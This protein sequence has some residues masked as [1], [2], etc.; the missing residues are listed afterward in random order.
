V[1]KLG[2][3]VNGHMSIRPRKAHRVVISMQ[4]K[5]GVLVNGHMSIRP[6]KARRV[7]ISMQLK[8]GVFVNGHMS[9]RPRKARGVVISMHLTETW[10]VCKRAYV[11][12]ILKTQ[13]KI[14]GYCY[15]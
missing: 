9:I 8:L 7:V 13:S 6:R 1:L 12:Q 11:Y 14:Y 15:N 3:F 5:L 10:S 4:L 2:V